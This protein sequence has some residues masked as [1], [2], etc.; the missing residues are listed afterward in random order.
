MQVDLGSGKKGSGKEGGTLVSWQL[1]FYGTETHPLSV[2]DSEQVSFDLNVQFA[3]AN[4][5]INEE[6]DLKSV[7]VMLPKEMTM[8]I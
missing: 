7:V 2:D 6:I 3:F 8:L 4:S 1:V 5:V